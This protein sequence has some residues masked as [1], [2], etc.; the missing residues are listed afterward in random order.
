MATSA[1]APVTSFL[2]TPCTCSTARWITRWKPM[3]GWV[4]TLLLG[5]RRGT[6]FVEV[7]GQVA[8]QVLDVAAAGAQHAAGGDV[9]EQRQQQ[10]LHG[11][12]LVALLARTLKG[13][14]ER[15]FKF[16]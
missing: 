9:V 16:L 7:G 12:E 2:P 5:G 10:M 8:A 4:S 13:A 6:C 11:N 3:V 14:V 15:K 1:F